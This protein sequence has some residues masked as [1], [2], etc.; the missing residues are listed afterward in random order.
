MS[1]KLISWKRND[2]INDSVNNICANM[3]ANGGMKPYDKSKQS[4]ISATL[5]YAAQTGRT[6]C[7]TCQ[8]QCQNAA[9]VAM[10]CCL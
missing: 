2:C 8:L 3:C 9:H 6:K 5:V 4:E 1:V 7:V 10:I